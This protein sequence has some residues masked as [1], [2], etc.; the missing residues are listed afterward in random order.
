MSLRDILSVMR[1]GQWTKNLILFA[2][3]IFSENLQNLNMFLEVF[4]AFILFC[5][6]SS[7]GYVINDMLDCKEDSQHPVKATRPI[8]SGRLKKSHAI[9]LASFLAILSLLGSYIL[10]VNF[11][12]VALAYFL[13][14]IAYSLFLK[15]VVIIDVMVIALGFVLR[16]VA[17]AVVIQVD[18]SSWLVVCTILL[19]LF[20]GFGKRRHEIVL[21]EGK[22]VNH[23]KI[24]TEYS[25]GFLDQ[26]IGV[27]TA[28]TV[29]A[30]AFYTLS[31]EISEKLGTK[32]MAL[33]IPFVLYGIFRYLYLI[34]QKEEGGSPAKMFLTDKPILI[35]ILLWLVAVILILYL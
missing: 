20:L 4:V 8:A 33:T 10:N 6:L 30:Y 16:A 27:V 11:F 14:N 18:I 1:P 2:G 19:A 13:L 32:Y 21:L 24:L 34:Y 5:L 3:I 15:H 7:V 17:G 23:R 22:A 25:L 29:V 35:D 9:F 31:P 26:M 12:V 28:S